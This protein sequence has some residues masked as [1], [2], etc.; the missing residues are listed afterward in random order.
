M[1][2]LAGTTS[3]TAGTSRTDGA[4]LRGFLTGDLGA[5]FLGVVMATA[6]LKWC[7]FLYP[8]GYL[9]T[10]QKSL[11]TTNLMGFIT[12]HCAHFERVFGVI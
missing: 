2:T 7:F 6:S 11:T 5:G 10:L 8:W 3:G 12:Q 4:F 1:M 9:N